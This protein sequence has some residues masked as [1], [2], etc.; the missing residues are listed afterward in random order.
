MAFDIYSSNIYL[1]YL[2]TYVVEEQKQHYFIDK[3][4]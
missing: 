1:Y 2:I 3:N 4:C